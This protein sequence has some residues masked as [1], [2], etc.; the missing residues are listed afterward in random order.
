MEM[1]DETT[2]R[3]RTDYVLF[4]IAFVGFLTAVSAAIVAVP[5]IAIA[6]GIVTVLTILSFR[7][8]AWLNE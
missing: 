6:A 8:R 3:A 7:F 5:G 2:D 1:L 4:G